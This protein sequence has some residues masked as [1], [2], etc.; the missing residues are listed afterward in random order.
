MAR[1]PTVGSDE[2]SW[3]TVLNDFLTE[4]HTSDGKTKIDT[5]ADSGSRPASPASGQ[6]G[7]NVETGR[8]ERYNGSS[9][10]EFA[11]N[12]TEDALI[13][14]STATQSSNDGSGGSVSINIGPT[15]S[16]GQKHHAIYDAASTLTIT[17]SGTPPSNDIAVVDIL[18]S[19]STTTV[20]VT[21]AS[22]IEDL[23]PTAKKRLVIL[24]FKDQGDNLV[25]SFLPYTVS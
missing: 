1:L 15:S 13:S 5:W 25:A 22:W 19:G 11:V 23:E 20:T 6:V 16:S 10:D 4:A 14:W 21:G 3:G 18:A 9:W 24:L 8:I 2:G 7:L 17:V 12:S